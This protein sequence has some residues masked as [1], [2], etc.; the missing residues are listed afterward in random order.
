MAPKSKQTTDDADAE[1][2]K[3]SKS[4]TYLLRR[5]ARDAGIDIDDEG[6]VKISDLSKYD[7]LR[8]IGRADLMR[9]IIDSN[10]TKVRY[11]LLGDYIRAYERSERKNLIAAAAAEVARTPPPPQRSADAAY[12]AAVAAQAAIAPYSYSPY[13]WPPMPPPL[14]YAGM[15]YASPY[16]SMGGFGGMGGWP[17]AAP[18]PT[19]TPPGHYTG[20]IK[21]YNSEKGFGFIECQATQMLY[22]RD[23][24]LHK[25]QIGDMQP[26]QWVMFSCEINKTGMP[27]A[28]DVRIVGEVAPQ[29]MQQFGGKGQGGGG[30]GAGKGQSK[31]KGKD[32][33]DG[34]GKGESKGEGKGQKKR[35]GP[36]RTGEQKPEVAATE[37][38]KAELRAV[39]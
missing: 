2:V 22:N 29:Q 17:P 10:N 31:G 34:K 9:V 27:Q 6:W 25:A 24:F 4:I 33:Q 19:A 38:P 37:A 36:R 5:G 28:K 7:Q 23:V 12:A 3:I 32:Q 16:A 13:G 15:P 18:Q 20:R 26:G 11:Q 35:D 8:G 14:P 21:S 39:S 30:K 1:R